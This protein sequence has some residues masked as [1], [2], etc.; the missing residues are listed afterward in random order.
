M[1][2][3]GDVHDHESKA[4][5]TNKG[6]WAAEK[7]NDWYEKQPWLVGCNF[8]PSTAIN[9]IEMWQAR[10][11][12]PE[13]IERELGW[14]AE[15]GFNSVRVFLHDLVWQADADGFRRRIDQF[16]ELAAHQGIRAMFVLFDDCWNAN[17]RLGE[18]PKPIPGIHNSGWVQSPG[19]NIVVNPRH[20]ARLE[21]YVK[22]VLEGFA[23]D[24]RVLMWDLYNEPGNGGLGEKSLELLRTTF[25]WARAVGPKQPLTAGI[26][27]DYRTLVEFQLAASDILS[28]HHY[29]DASDLRQQI[30]RFKAYGR[31][32]ICTEYMA[33]PRGSRFS[34]HLPVFRQEGVGCY[35]WGLVRGRTQTIFPWESPAGAPEPEEWFHD[36]LHEDGTPFDKSEI[37]FIRQIRNVG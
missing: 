10:S 30:R 22:G 7:A 17:P 28:F 31:P 23:T 5:I 27:A 13:T 32:A 18:Q 21:S 6:R 3:I 33:R 25:E 12:D 26:W 14:A 37:A 8:I 15:I 16:L 20:W 24:E 36:L 11:F 4:E 29:N 9:Q 19:A 34:T 1:T 35:N 2:G